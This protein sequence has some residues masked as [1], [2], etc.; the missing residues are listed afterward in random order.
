MFPAAA[1]GSAISFDVLHFSL[2]RAE[3]PSNEKV[4]FPTSNDHNSP[5]EHDSRAKNWR[6]LIPRTCRNFLDGSRGL[7]KRLV[8]EEKIRY[9]FP[10]GRAP[11]VPRK[12]IGCNAHILALALAPGG[13]LPPQTGACRPPACAPLP[14]E[15]TSLAKRGEH[16][17]D[18]IIDIRGRRAGG[19]WR[20]SPWGPWARA[21]GPMI[22][23]YF[24]LF[25][26]KSAYLETGSCL[27]KII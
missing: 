12:P 6:K 20:G 18:S 24:G 13:A 17:R 3:S 7:K 8:F 19:R 27:F 14:S 1:A 22:F 23:A 25:C 2:N 10:G 9:F 15:S 5:L 16:K 26:L 11:G 4:I 21:H